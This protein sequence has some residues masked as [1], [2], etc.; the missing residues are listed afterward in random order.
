P[1][2]ER[3]MNT[4]LG[5]T[6]DFSMAELD[7]E[8]LKQARY[9]YWEGYLVTSDTSRAAVLAARRLAAEQG[10]KTAMTFSDPS[11]VTYF[12]DGVAELLGDGVDILFCNTEEAQTFTGTD[13]LDAAIAALKP[14]AGRLVITLGSKGAMVV[15]GQGRISIDPHPVRAIDTNGAGDMFAGA[16]LYAISQGMDDASAGRLASLA[17]SRIVSVYGTRLSRAVHAE[18][19]SAIQG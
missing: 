5:I 16:F 17:A 13:N 8:A 12:R 3:T 14:C 4:Y 11:M 15:N 6:T 1:D 9:L 19:L 10:I 2:A 18:L 7:L